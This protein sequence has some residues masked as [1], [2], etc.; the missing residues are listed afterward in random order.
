M[1]IRALDSIRGLLLLQMTLEHFGK[2][3]SH[4]LYQCFGFFSA[5]EGFFFLSGFVGMLAATSKQVKDPTQSWM[6]RRAGRIWLYHAVSLAAMCIVAPFALHRIAYLFQPIYNHPAAAIPLGAI[7]VHTPEY[8]DILPQYVLLMLAGSVIFPIYVKAKNKRQILLLWLGSLALWAV[9]QFGLRDA[10]G[11]LYPKWVNHGAHDPFSWQ[12]VYFSGAAVSAWWKR[13]DKERELVQKITPWLLVPFI[14][15]YLWKS[16]YLPLPSPSDFLVS[17]EHLG[18]IRYVDFMT[19]MMLVSAIVRKW[20][21][22]LDFRFTNVIGKHS[23]DVYTAHTILLCLWFATPK[24][25]R[26][27]E[28]WNIVV[29]ITAC[30]LLWLLSKAREPKA[31]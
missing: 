3:I 1:R 17:R 27:H 25:I 13:A 20:P 22:A 12:L 8:F 16:Q 6:R 26:Y 7:L 9:A 15:C 24:S 21:S 31:K 10:V 18:I 30:L 28:P 2:P 29:P 4:Y 14:F 11:G 5:A 19:F 23:L